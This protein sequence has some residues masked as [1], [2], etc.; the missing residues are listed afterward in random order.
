GYSSAKR[1]QFAVAQ[2][3]CFADLVVRRMLDLNNQGDSEET[4]RL[5][6]RLGDG[7]QSALD[8]LLRLHR[9]YLVRLVSARITPDLAARVDASDIV[10]EA[11]LEITRRIRD[12]LAQRPASFRVWARGQ[13]LDRFI[14][15]W[16]RHVQSGKRSIQREERVNDSS[17]A[18]VRTLLT[19]TPSKLLRRQETVDHVRSLIDELAPIDREI[20]TLR[21]AE[22]LSSNEAAEVL[23]IDP[24]TARQR[25]GRALRRLHQKLI[26]HGITP[27][28]GSE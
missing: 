10:Q 22:S 13:V 23:G 5:L 25:F 27:G 19:E 15:Q 2:A 6:E 3:H 1:S 17:M 21:H 11:Q 20:L 26:E 16:R 7:E 24:S 14:D 12:Y 9:P 18:I 28:E 4:R 8:D